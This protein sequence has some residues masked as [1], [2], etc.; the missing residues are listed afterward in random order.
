[1]EGEEGGTWGGV[2]ESKHERARTFGMKKKKTIFN[3]E[4]AIKKKKKLDGGKIKRVQQ[5]RKEKGKSRST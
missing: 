5:V 1:L 3:L 4:D 2:F